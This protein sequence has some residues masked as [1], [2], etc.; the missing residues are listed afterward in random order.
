M[1]THVTLN[2]DLV[3]QEITLEVQGPFLSCED[4]ALL[5]QFLQENDFTVTLSIDPIETAPTP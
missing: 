1:I 4:G 5:A 2:G 3:P